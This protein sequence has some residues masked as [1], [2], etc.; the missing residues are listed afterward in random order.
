MKKIVASLF[1]VTALLGSQA[2]AW[3]GVPYADTANVS[4][5][6][7]SVSGGVSIESD[8]NLY[9]LRAQYGFM[10][11]VS[12]FGGIGMVD[13]DRM[14]AEPYFLLGGKY[15]LPVQLPFDAAL[16]MSFGF[17]RFSDKGSHSWVH[18]S[19]SWKTDTD[20]M[21]INAALLASKPLSETFSLYGA[22]GISYQQTKFKGSSTAQFRGVERQESYSDSN[23]DTDPAVALGGTY[24]VTD[25]ISVYVE[26]THIDRTFFSIGGT[27][28]F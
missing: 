2:H 27:F 28:K 17:A 10:E 5:G 15:V 26:A 24:S 23:S 22:V 4:K 25:N 7:T 16:R 13:F 18:G 20:L 11:G 8:V 14:D 1:V 12:V 3:L 6:D 9:G 21:T 19:S